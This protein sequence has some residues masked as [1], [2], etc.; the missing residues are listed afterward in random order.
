MFTILPTSITVLVSWIVQC[1][2]RPLPH[3]NSQTLAMSASA[4]PHHKSTLIMILNKSFSSL[5]TPVLSATSLDIPMRL[6]NLV[7]PQFPNLI[8]P[9]VLAISSLLFSITASIHLTQPQSVTSSILLAAYYLYKWCIISVLISMY[10]PFC[11]SS[12]VLTPFPSHVG[13]F[14]GHFLSL[15]FLPHVLHFPIPRILCSIASFCCSVLTHVWLCRNKVTSS[16]PQDVLGH[17]KTV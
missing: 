14:D 12:C 17:A 10:L 1:P 4:H 13:T 11:F 16:T 9:L 5:G 6:H 7:T 2:V 3:Y 8:A 15:H